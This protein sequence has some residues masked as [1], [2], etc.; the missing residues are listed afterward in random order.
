M[1]RAMSLPSPSENHAAAFVYHDRLTRHLL[2]E[3]HVFRPYRLRYT[4]ELLEALGAFSLGN[5]ALVEPRQARVEE[6]LTFHSP[7]YVEA[8]AALSRGERLEEAALFNFAAGGM[9]DNPVYAGMYDA[10]LWTTGASLTAAEELLSGRRSV[11]VNFSGGL[12]HAMPTHA[13]GF[14]IFDDPVIAIK[15]MALAGARVAYVDIDCHHGDGVQIGF[16]DTD[17]VLTISLHESGEFLFPGSGFVNEVGIDAGRGFAVNVPLFPYTDD[18][19]YLW[20][21]REVVPPL[22]QAFRPDVLVTQLGI[23]THVL[24]PITHIRL[25]VQGYTQVVRELAA[26]SPGRWLALGG[27][28]YDIGAVMRAWTRA[29]GVMLGHEWPESAPVEFAARYGVE[30]FDD[31]E[32][33]PLP[34]EVAARVRGYAEQSVAAIRRDVFP[35]HGLSAGA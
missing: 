8:V 30:R 23:D 12:H 10:A 6:A 27:G 16:F 7:A 9:G 34:P 29:Y 31:E 2:S 13:S 11:A 21:F 15:H 1:L 20:A 24:D 17:Q 18:E 35:V 14:C 33:G 4:Y 5:S 25:T 19:T 28:G 3:T 22:V 32:Q 26:L